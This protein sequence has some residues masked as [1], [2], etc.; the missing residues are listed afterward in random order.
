MAVGGE[1]IVNVPLS[2][3]ELGLYEGTKTTKPEKLETKSK[4]P[5]TIT[6]LK[7]A[8]TTTPNN[9]TKIAN[10][11]K[12]ETTTEGHLQRPYQP[13]GKFKLCMYNSS[14]KFSHEVEYENAE[15]VG[16]KLKLYAGEKS[17]YETE[18]GGVKYKITVKSNNTC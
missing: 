7:C 4:Y 9:E 10:T 3:L 5:V 18:A 8:T 15:E 1:T 13:F 11:H 14:T 12:Q 16:A 17:S 2:F 6:N